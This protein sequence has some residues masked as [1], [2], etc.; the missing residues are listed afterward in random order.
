MTTIRNETTPSDRHR[1]RVAAEREAYSYLPGAVVPDLTTLDRLAVE[2]VARKAEHKAACQAMLAV[3][4][5]SALRR[6]QDRIADS[7]I[8]RAATKASDAADDAKAAW[9]A[10]WKRVGSPISRQQR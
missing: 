4:E 7:K 10:E 9:V 2:V 1:E 8:R 5:K 3:L 6:A